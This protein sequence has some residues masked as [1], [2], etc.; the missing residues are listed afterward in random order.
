MTNEADT[1][2]TWGREVKA[3]GDGRVGGYLVFFSGPSDPDLTGGFRAGP[4]KKLDTLG[5]EM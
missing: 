5:L 1:L 4:P 2:V 3:L